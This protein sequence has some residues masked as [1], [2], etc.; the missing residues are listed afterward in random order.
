VYTS[1]TPSYVPKSSGSGYPDLVEPCSNNE[2]HQA[3]SYRH[4]VESERITSRSHYLG[5]YPA[6]SDSATTSHSNRK[7]LSGG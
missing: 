4:Q 6:V 3:Q 5:G 2:H 1:G 7:S